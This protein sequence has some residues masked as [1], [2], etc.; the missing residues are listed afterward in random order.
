MVCVRGVVNDKFGLLCD[1]W[2]DSS[3]FYC[4]GNVVVWC[5]FCLVFFFL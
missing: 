2:Y 1:L 3:I 4:W 5:V